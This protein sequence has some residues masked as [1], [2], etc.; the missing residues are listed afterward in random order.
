MTTGSGLGPNNT[1]YQ[2]RETF[3]SSRH[4]SLRTS[5]RNHLLEGQVHALQEERKTTEGRIIQNIDRRGPKQQH[6]WCRL[7]TTAARQGDA[8]LR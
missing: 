6:V 2:V 1:L 4:I 7:Q 8:D 5:C 3:E